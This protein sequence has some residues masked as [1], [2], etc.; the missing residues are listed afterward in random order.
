MPGRFNLL[1]LRGSGQTR[2]HQLVSQIGLQNP[3]GPH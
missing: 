1:E 3:V 2:I